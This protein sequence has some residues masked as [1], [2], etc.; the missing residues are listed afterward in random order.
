MKNS[1]ENKIKMLLTN[2]GCSK[3]VINGG[4]NWLLNKYEK[5]CGEI[6]NHTYEY[7]D[8]EYSN[9]I[10][11]REILEFILDNLTKDEGCNYFEKIKTIDSRILIHLEFVEEGL[12]NQETIKREKWDS[13]K[14]WWYFYRPK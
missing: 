8:Y 6:E 14:Q 12:I 9:D 2:R 5:L 7:I 4:I 10:S 3:T 1:L 13:K 11:V